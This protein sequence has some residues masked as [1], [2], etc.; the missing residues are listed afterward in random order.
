LSRISSDNLRAFGQS[1]EECNSKY[2]N[3]SAKLLLN[4]KPIVISPS[5]LPTLISYYERRGAVF[6]ARLGTSP[7]SVLNF[8]LKMDLMLRFPTR[9]RISKALEESMIPL[10]L[11]PIWTEVISVKMS[12]ILQFQKKVDISHLITYT[13]T[14]RSFHLRI[15]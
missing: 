14:V 3:T 5:L 2:E 11:P 12:I 9:R 7:L 6:G 15:P 10:F 13:A 8:S 1:M 4:G